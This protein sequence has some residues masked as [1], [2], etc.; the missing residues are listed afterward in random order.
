MTALIRI[1]AVCMLCVVARHAL[2]FHLQHGHFVLGA[3][4]YQGIQGSSQTIAITGLIGDRYNVSNQHD[5]NAIVELGY[6]LDGTHRE[7]LG[8]DYGLNVFYLPKTSV[9]GTIDQELIYSNL[10]YSY[11][12]SHLPVYAA[13]KGYLQ[14]ENDRFAVTMDAGIGPNF[15]QTSA[16]QDWSLNGST[17]SPDHAF[18]GR[19]NVAFTAM[20]GIGLKVHHAIGHLPLE[21]GYRLFYLGE[22]YFNARSTQLLNHLDTGNN[23]AQAVMCSVQI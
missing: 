2:S 6:L 1:L 14:P 10:A 22:G 5:S 4:A 11:D 15:L 17:T 19:W 13:V 21:C 3:G 7:Q 8:I 20:A 23:Y 16:Y 18:S 12:V 9:S